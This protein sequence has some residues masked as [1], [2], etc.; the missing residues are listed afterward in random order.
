MSQIDD[1][2]GGADPEFGAASSPATAKSAIDDFLAE[3]SAP[4][5][6]ATHAK[7]LG[8]S[9]AKGVVA[10]PEAAVG[11][12]DL[13]T[14]G[15]AGKLLENEGGAF[16]FRPK[17]AKDFLSEQHTDDYKAKQQEFQSAD[18]IM[19]KAGVALSNP[20]LVANEIAASLP[21][22]G[23]GGVASR[24]LMAVGARGVAA[25]AGGVGPAIPG[26]LA[27]T[28][29][30]EA[31]PLVAGALGEGIAGAGSAAEQMRQES[32]DGELTGKQAG[33]A[34]LTGAATA[35]FGFAGGRVATKLGIGDVDTM[36]AQ[37]A[38]RTAGQASTKSI[39]RQVIEGA[40]SEGLLE[41]LPQSV[42][43]QVLQNLALNKPWDDGVD[44]AIVM[45]T[46]AGMGMGGAAAGVAGFSNRGEQRRIDQEAAR[47][48]AARKQ[49]DIDNYVDTLPEHQQN[50][51]RAQ[52]NAQLQA[53]A[54]AAEL[55]DQEQGQP[56]MQPG[57][58]NDYKAT[59]AWAKPPED[60]LADYGNP[61]DEIQ[62][63]TGASFQPQ[64]PDPV[65]QAVQQA[66]DAGGALSAAAGL[67]MDSGAAPGYMPPAMEQV[68]EPQEDAVILQNRER[69]SEASIAQMQSIAAQPDYLRVGPSREM[70]TGAPVVF[71]DLPGTALLGRGE[72]VVDGRGSRVATQYAIVDAGDVI[73]SNNADGTPVAEYAQ[74]LPGKLR[75]VAGNG[76]T[77]GLQAA[78]Q[79]GTAQQSYTP[80][81]LQDAQALG[82]DPQAVA[83]MQRPVLVRV[84]SKE[85]VTPNM[86][87][88]TNISSTLNLS[89]Q[90]RAA[91]D[92]NRIDVASLSFDDYGNPTEESLK[93]FVAA[94]PE[95]ERG[96]MV[97]KIGPTRQ[98]SD[99]LMA[100]VF[101]QAYQDDELVR[102]YAQA[103]DPDARAVLGAVAGASGVM[104]NLSGA[105]EFDVRAAVADAVKMA[106]NAKRQGLKLS[107]VAQNYDM[108]ISSEAYVVAEFM[109]QNAR[110]PKRMAEGLR[111]WGQ[112][113]LQQA[114]VAEENQYQGGLL[115]PTPT[116]TRE[117]IFA[118]LGSESNPT[119][120]AIAGRAPVDA[121]QPVQ[122]DIEGAPTQQPQEQVQSAP[123][124]V[125][126]NFS[127]TP[128]AT[129]GSR[130]DAVAGPS[131][132]PASLKEAL[133]YH[134]A[135]KR[136][137]PP[138]QQ[139][140]QPDQE[141]VQTAP[142]Q[143][144]QMDA[145][146]IWA[147]MQPDERKAA[148]Q[149]AGLK[150]IQVGAIGK[151]NWEKINPGIQAQ[152]SQSIADQGNWPTLSG[153]RNQG[154]ADAIMAGELPPDGADMRMDD[155]GR[156]VQADAPT[157][158]AATPA[159]N[160]QP[161]Q[162]PQVETPNTEAATVAAPALSFYTP[163]DIEAQQAQ[164]EQTT[165]AE[166]ARKRAE[167]AAAT[168]ADDRKRIAQASVI[169]ADTFELGQDP[170]DSLTGQ[171]D[172]LADASVPVIA[173]EADAVA[174]L[175]IL[176]AGNIKEILDAA[177]AYADKNF[178]NKPIRIKD[179]NSEVLIARS[180]IKHALS[181]GAGEL[182]ALAATDLENLLVNA[183]HMRSEPD[184]SGR[185]HI[186]AAHFYSSRL[187]VGGK[188]HDIG[189]VVRELHDG[190]KYYDHFELKQK[191]ASPA[192]TSDNTPSSISNGSDSQPAAGDSL[193][194]PPSPA[195][196]KPTSTKEGIAK[197]RAEKKAKA[198]QQ[199]TPKVE[200]KPA[201]NPDISFS[202]TDTP[203]P[204]ARGV[205]A[206]ARM[207]MFNR[208]AD[209]IAA[210][211]ANAPKIEV[212]TNMDDPEIP[213]SARKSDAKQRSNGASGHVEGFWHE[214]TVYLLTDNLQSAADAVRV[215]LH[216][217]LGH[218]GLRGVFGPQLDAILSKVIELRRDDVLAKAKQYGLDP[219]SETD[220]K[221]AAEEVL[222]TMAQKTPKLPL[223]RRAIAAIRSWLRE[224][225]PM[226]GS[227]A[228]TDGEIIR[229]YILPARGFVERGGSGS[230]AG[231]AVARQ[232]RSD[233][234][235]PAPRF[236]RVSQA[237]SN[238]VNERK[239]VVAG[240]T[241]RYTQAQMDAMR[242]VGFI[243]EQ[244]SL[245]ERAQALW[246]DAGKKLAQGIVDQF[247][248]V[249]EIS[250]DAYA[251][252]RLSKGASGAF[253]TLLKGGKLK[254]SDGVYNFDEA[255]RGGVVDKLLTPL[256]GEHH[257]FF[258]WVAANR[259]ERLMIEGRENLFTPE[260]ITALKTLADG[261][262]PFDYTVQHGIRKGR[263]TR[264][265]AEAY[266]DSL[267]TFNAFN[268][269][270]LDMAEQSGL[271]D[272]E[273]RAT[274]ENEFYVPFY[275]VADE[276]SGG[277]RGMNIKGSV[278]R[279]KAFEQLKGGKQKLN[280]DLLD[281]TLM[282][283]AHLLDAAAK[284]RAAKATLEAAANVGVAIEAPKGTLDSMA[285]SINK[286]DGIVWFMDGGQKRHFMVDDPY[287]MTAISSLEFA[288]MNSPIMN[289]MG[290][291]KRA[292]TIGVTAS[293]FFKVRNLI[294][295]SVQV[296]GV[297]GIS[298][299]PLKN[300]TEGW[301]LTDPKNDA[302]FRLLAGGGTIHFGTMM[303]GSEAKRVQ[304]L[305]ESGVDDSTVL[306]NDHKIKQ[307]YR[308]F[309]EPGI[310]A[311][312]E[313]GNRGEAVNRASLYDQLTKQGVNHAEA[314]LMA[315]DLM[316]FSMQGSFTSIR[317]LT[318]VVPFFNARLQGMY[319]LGRAA[320]ED[321]KRMA[322]VTGAI[323]MA[324]LALLAAYGDD[325]DWKK[326]EESD[327]N[328][329]WWFKLSGTAFRIPKPFE[330]GAI[331]TLA[332]RSA[333]YL[334]DDEMTGKRF[335]AQVLKLM[336]DNLS[337]NPI[338]QAVKPI[339][340]VY[341]NK[342]SF[343]DAPIESMGM[344]KLKPEYRFND[345][346][347][348]V[349]RA[350]STAANAVTNT[351]GV[352][353][354]SPVQIDHLLRGYLGWLG[355][356]AVGT[357]DMITRPAMSQPAQATPDYWKVATGG[358]VSDL[359]DAP[360]RYVSSIYDQA[361]ELEQAYGT[362]RALQKSGKPQEAAEFFAENRDEITRHRSVAHVKAAESKLNE[363]IRYIERSDMGSDT[364][365]EAIRAIRAQKEGLAKM[366]AQRG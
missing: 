110:S 228:L 75:A 35:G 155:G 115:E 173:I 15:K 192:G 195:G 271:I 125:P 255:N 181:S 278:V 303:E 122:S 83:G 34:A 223:V 229:S 335:R 103:Q 298:A 265:R 102:M 152:L 264:K 58:P 77:A 147:G 322:Y 39:P 308:K 314:S 268:K 175:D 57:N 358:M 238:A 266:R 54:R 67:A 70:A 33:L 218:H 61:D 129:M 306:N 295:D 55:A 310:T 344:E 127:G 118:A 208:L 214:G 212:V 44:G 353:S 188:V 119:G 66:A 126:G 113:A 260:A 342:D 69:N 304:A 236:S 311:Y 59:P 217:S 5:S 53:E 234:A 139:A 169:A 112:L 326:R 22:M 90:E 14:G 101:K 275:R 86:G 183:K 205:P 158:A 351:I 98:A 239:T 235:D 279:Q 329:F 215:L 211:W 289:V 274:W 96:D 331:G 151:A 135:R 136:A 301:K 107:D 272:A 294:R 140:A 95:S 133:A 179:D 104:S 253:E 305:V 43:E 56:D 190:R 172:L 293:P 330:L 341:A 280:H 117:Q 242:D 219:S 231:T 17:Q 142:Q 149:A 285:G 241:N 210:H 143:S 225:V 200:T 178:G 1:F 157:T 184:K 124:P 249:K 170:M 343:R 267:T 148:A 132:G 328:N 356:F 213:E 324:S 186:K 27:R 296:I 87:D 320:K 327:R 177:R 354:P 232:S 362:W 78:Y 38:T 171:K 48:E 160:Q 180:G 209:S 207:A 347:S 26:A 309:I 28:V 131:F 365:R 49:A 20:S 7:D 100:A 360:S 197:I 318:Q 202:R 340:D 248:P 224:H 240:S 256:G 159:T 45:G 325:D 193:S 297:S 189:I 250:K 185:A 359:R 277:V 349:A 80:E 111:R 319:K 31:A 93:G 284:N 317:F 21:V 37:G 116:L 220:L 346:T 162:S 206:K 199:E 6:L 65:R 164:Q 11:L 357:A 174:K 121:G 99:R 23:A 19:A 40:I 263:T 176:P 204:P 108:D 13:V 64:R 24:G 47:Q 201:A 345:R 137:E 251:L 120:Q 230:N 30:I 153:E 130:T 84:M 313:L 270:V 361:K 106:V 105:G 198:E 288:G 12:A 94:T 114:R 247:A 92:I 246:Q 194:L 222:A 82:I 261:D 3:P 337:M 4:P 258:R 269:N 134:H 42:S 18:G 196:S 89:A 138:A 25:G 221:E 71:G 60:A 161:A 339:L 76:R 163:A 85:D 245:K 332:E 355:T 50:A 244:P 273:S 282:N 32:T 62:Q 307:F 29:G 167:T 16:G 233:A 9:L 8:L 283:W 2:L 79:M 259:A 292:L 46:L 141:S 315:R 252:L 350:A 226:M 336:G 128:T 88:R 68:Q 302:Y 290:S 286:K 363:R 187:N 168:E 41:E 203:P 334:F 97:D 216:E 123:L 299:T 364:K 352:N 51:A 366:L 333:E 150:P 156:M 154:R 281:N 52:L 348:M 74:G 81:L 191:S 287:L 166:A 243:V 312:N 316:D 36:I 165:K 276:E 338:P 146:Q 144:T 323:A 72:T 262:L 63:S 73:A 227:L 91:N 300:V 257:D 10:V 182:D 321:P 291:F 145:G 254:L 109:A 237:I